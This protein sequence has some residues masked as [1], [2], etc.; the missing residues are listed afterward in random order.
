[1]ENFFNSKKDLSKA[2][3]I[4]RE[5]FQ[6]HTVDSFDEA[7]ERQRIAEKEGIEN[8]KALADDQLKRMGDFIKK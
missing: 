4:C 1:M 5:L 2:V 6:K 8:A 3:E 7:Q